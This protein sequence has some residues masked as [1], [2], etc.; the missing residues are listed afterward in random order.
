MGCFQRLSGRTVFNILAAVMLI[1][2][3]SWCGIQNCCQWRNLR[4]AFAKYSSDD[5]MKELEKTLKAEQAKG[6]MAALEAQNKFLEKQLKMMQRNGY[7]GDH[8]PGGSPC[9]KC[10]LGLAMLCWMIAILMFCANCCWCC[11]NAC[12]GG[13]G[14]ADDSDV[15]QDYSDYDGRTSD[16]VVCPPVAMAAPD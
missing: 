4:D 11:P 7:K 5:E 1:G 12:K 10:V 9:A 3:C 2:G 16:V 15:P 6:P 13:F 8:L 14:A